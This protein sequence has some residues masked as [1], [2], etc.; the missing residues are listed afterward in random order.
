LLGLAYGA[1]AQWSRF[2]LLR[3]LLQ[4]WSGQDGRLLRAFALALAVAVPATQALAAWAGIDLNQSL[5]RQGN[6]AL[7]L[8]LLG[9][10]LFGVGMTL[11]NA[12]AARSLVLLGTGNLRS[13][14]VLL[15]LGVSAYMTLSG[16][17]APLRVALDQSLRVAL[18]SGSLPGLL[19]AAGVAQ[20]PATWL[21]TA[22][23]SLALLAFSLGHRPLRQSPRHW[24]G[25]LLIGLLI[26]AGW[27]IT[28]VLGADDF[29]PVRR[30]SL[31]FVAPVG[32]SLQYLMPFQKVAKGDDLTTSLLDL[33]KG[34][35]GHQTARALNR[36]ILEH[37]DPLPEHQ[38][39]EEPEE[40]GSEP[41][42]PEEEEGTDTP[43]DPEPGEQPEVPEDPEPEPGVWGDRQLV[44]HDEFND[45]Q[46]DRSR[47]INGRSWSYPGGGPV[48]P[49][50]NKLDHLDP[51][52]VKVKDGELVI[53]AVRDGSVWRTGLITTGNAFPEEDRFALQTGDFHAALVQMPEN[54]IGAWPALWTWN[55]GGNEIDS[56][57]WHGDNPNLLE[58]TN[59][60]NGGGKYVSLPELVKPG[61]WVWIATDFGATNNRYYV[62]ETLDSL[63]LVFEDGTG[64]GSNWRAFAII[65]L[66]I[67]AGQWHPSP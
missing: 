2:C 56:F 51:D 8:I 25:G 54:P 12:C 10:V 40:P 32:E 52:A 9:G 11:A 64:V 49:N 36:R 53:T 3:G 21:V 24:L 35:Y 30:T 17:L 20:P 41:E 13:L 38:P 4:Q 48:N 37:T 65:N 16:V 43:S 47:W 63:Q 31:T 29:E 42:A 55:N 5:Y 28:G 62:G 60:V 26:A 44:F 18:P 14:T 23:L 34:V 59:H 1:L 45:D 15:V 6:A 66:S 50:D 39:P 19:G 33:E 27:W 58:I 61:G 7:P 67:S 46:L 22:A 57:E